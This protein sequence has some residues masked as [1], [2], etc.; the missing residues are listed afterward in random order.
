[1][2][3]EEER[4]GE[5]EEDLTL[6]SR[7]TSPGTEVIG[8]CRN[9]CRSAAAVEENLVL[10]VDSER[11]GKNREHG[12][13]RDVEAEPSVAATS[14][15]RAW[16]AGSP[17]R[18]CGGVGSTKRTERDEEGRRKGGGVWR[19]GG[20]VARVSRGRRLAGYM[21]WGELVRQGIRRGRKDRAVKKV[22][23]VAVSAPFAE[24]DDEQG[25]EGVPG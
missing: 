6:W 3:L 22:G 14:P 12:Q 23:A 25:V 2:A 8:G 21:G 18:S 9:F 5:K 19:V 17:A 13:L 16:S 11:A 15:V 7:N 10:V 1:V 4:V 20:G 24:D